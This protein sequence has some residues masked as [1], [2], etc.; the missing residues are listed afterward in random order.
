MKKAIV[1]L[2]IGFSLAYCTPSQQADQTTTSS[3]TGSDTTSGTSGMGTTG[4]MSDTTGSSGTM[5]DTSTHH[6]DSIPQ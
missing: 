4:T 2:S 1:L 5:S 6:T 3:S